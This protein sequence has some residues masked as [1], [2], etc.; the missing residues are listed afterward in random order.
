MLHYIN[1]YLQYEIL[2]R[3]LWLQYSLFTYLESTTRANNLKKFDKN[4]WNIEA[5]TSTIH[6]IPSTVRLFCS[7]KSR[8]K[9]ATNL[10][11]DTD[12]EDNADSIDEDAQ[13][14]T[15]E[16]QVSHLVKS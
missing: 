2:S 12:E 14:E 4:Y 11:A 5:R 1:M 15:N 10:W 8:C 16:D 6:D 7:A 3:K 9:A 13:I